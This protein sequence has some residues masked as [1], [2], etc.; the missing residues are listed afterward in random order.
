[1]ELPLAYRFDGLPRDQT[2]KSKWGFFELR[3]KSD[4]KE[5]RRLELTFHT[6]LEKV[7]VEKPDFAAFQKF[8][9]D[10]SKHWRVWLTLKATQDLADA[11]ALEVLTTLTKGADRHS[12]TIL[13]KLYLHHNRATDARRIVQLARSHHPSDATLLDLA[14]QCASGAQEDEE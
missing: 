7:L 4:A 3:V 2:V 13:A 10:V 9:D 11:P 5:P 1:I 12:A 8:H 14:V 6:R